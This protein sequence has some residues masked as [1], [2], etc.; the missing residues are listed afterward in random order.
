MVPGIQI[1]TIPQ[2]Y[3]LYT[4]VKTLA[5]ERQIL[6]EQD[7]V[8][9]SMIGAHTQTI[10]PIRLMPK[11]CVAYVG[12]VICKTPLQIMAFGTILMAQLEPGL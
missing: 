6:Q 10:I 5:M 4:T 3:T 7:V 11:K 2:L 12:E 1:L 9:I 8:S